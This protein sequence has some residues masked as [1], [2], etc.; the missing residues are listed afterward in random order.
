MINTKI[1]D[2]HMHCGIQNVTLPFDV[3]KKYLD[4]AGIQGACLFAPVED[5]YDRYNYDFEDNAAWVTCRQQANRYLL[6]IQEKHESFFSYYFVWN[7]FRKDELK[8][9]YRAVK[10]HRHEYEP[11]YQYD[12]P[13]CEAFL[14]EVYRLE[15]PIVLEESFE[16]T[17]YFIKRVNGR[18]PVIIP[19]MGGLNGGFPTLFKSGTWDN[20]T[21]Y[22][23]TALAPGWE[24]A[25]F[26]NRYGSD[27]L[28]FGSDFPFGTPGNELQAVIR[29]NLG[30]EDFDKVVCHNILRLLKA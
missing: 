14:Q 13:L 28:L 22:A 4:S 5:I 19:H 7:D 10:W 17:Q 27:R 25:E 9:G 15:L 26:L 11:V 16:N 8:K 18:T 12:A 6:E 30:K 29:L 1:I 20:E 2:S 21:I 23:D 3:I 24:I